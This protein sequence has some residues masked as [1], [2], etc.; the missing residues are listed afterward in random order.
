MRSLKNARY[1][2]TAA[3]HESWRTDMKK[4]YLRIWRSM[5]PA[6]VTAEERQTGVGPPEYRNKTIEIF[7]ATRP[8]W[9]SLVAEI[10][11]RVVGLCR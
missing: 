1:D 4:F 6:I 3:E 11:D 8:L 2:L 9:A 10:D 7:A 5:I